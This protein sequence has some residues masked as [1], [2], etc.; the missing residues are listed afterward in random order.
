MTVS[1]QN[2]GKLT[3]VDLKKVRRDLSKGFRKGLRR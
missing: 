3:P 2:C 1:G